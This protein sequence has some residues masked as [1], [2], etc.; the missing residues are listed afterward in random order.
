MKTLVL[1]PIAMWGLVIVCC[2]YFWYVKYYHPLH[3]SQPKYN[4][5]PAR[6]FQSPIKEFIWAKTTNNLAFE[7][8]FRADGTVTWMYI[9]L[10]NS[11][12]AQ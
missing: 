12:F 7:I 8:Q 11:P 10:T 2:T 3:P 4:I 9:P 5:K 1:A 6:I